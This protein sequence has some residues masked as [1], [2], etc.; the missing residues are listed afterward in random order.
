M[1]FLDPRKKRAYKIRLFI[2]YALMAIAIGLGALVLVYSAYGYSINTKTGV[3]V[4]NSLLFVDSKP[5][6]AD[7]YINGAHHGTTSSRLVLPAGNY[8][9]KLSKNG[10][11]DWQRGVELDASSVKYYVYPFLFPKTPVSA[12]MQN[13]TAEPAFFSQTPDNHWLLVQTASTANASIN[14]DEYDT[15]KPTQAAQQLSLPDSIL[16]NPSLPGSSIS[17]VEWST[18]NNHALLL[19]VYPGGSEYVVF[20]RSNPSQSFNV[21]RLFNINPSEVALRNKS[22]NQ[23]HL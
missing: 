2:G 5:G 12:A 21:N 17:L 11:R 8:S 22:I 19:H 6:G 1:D 13:Y 20:N 7:I 16:T 18:D 15:T 4:Q 3:V 10:Y 14:F 9:L 23:L